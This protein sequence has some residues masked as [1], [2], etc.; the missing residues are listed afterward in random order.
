MRLLASDGSLYDADRS[1]ILSLAA[2][3]VRW[4]IGGA[5]LDARLMPI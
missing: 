1:Y 5:V 4:S 2:F 3:V